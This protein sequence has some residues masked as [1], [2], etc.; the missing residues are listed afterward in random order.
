MQFEGALIKEQNVTFA[1]VVVK[2]FVLQ[3]SFEY[4]AARKSFCSAFP[5]IPIILM[6]QNSKGIPTYQGRPDIVRF[7][8]QI[9]PSRIPWKS[10]SLT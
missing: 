1:I 3:N 10:Y 5:G 7:L 9:T 8:T 4:D 6:S 2:P